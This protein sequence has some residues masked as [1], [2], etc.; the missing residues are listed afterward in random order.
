MNYRHLYHAGNFGDVIK[1]IILIELISSL[2]KKPTPFCFLDTH[3]GTGCYDLFSDMSE[4]NKEYS[5]GILKIIEAEKPPPLVKLY[6]ACVNRI[7]NQLTGSKFS[8]LRYYPGSPFIAHHF[9]RQQ[10]KMIACELHPI[11][12]Q[13]LKTLF[14]DNKEIATHHMDGYLALKAFLPPREKRGLIL[15]DPPYENPEEFDRLSQH[16]PIA[17][18]RF[19]TGIFC[20]WYPIKEKNRLIRFQQ[21]IRRTI[22][23]PIFIIELTIYPDLP[24]HL[25][26]CG[27]M[28]IN[29]PWQFDQNINKILPWL[30][31]VLTINKQG[32]YRAYLLK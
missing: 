30:W 3:A 9:A 1:H 5:G 24:N 13:N 10:D 32:T 18:K 12:Y 2:L 25:N 15:I 8:S 31:N 6:L 26:G 11:E 23:N 28:I 20:L 29:P 17:L 19:P 27:L 4:K 21:T 16:L 7:N 22:G 14:K